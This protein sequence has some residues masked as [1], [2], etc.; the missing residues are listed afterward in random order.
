MASWT[1]PADQTI[2][3]NEQLGR[4]LFAEPLLSGAV[5]Q[6][7]FRGLDLRNFQEK[8]DREYSLDRLGR[9]NVERAVIKYLQP[10]AINAAQ[11]FREPK[12]FD[13]W[14][15][16][17]ARELT[18]AKVGKHVEIFASPVR[19]Q[20][21]EENI[22]H[23]HAL[24]PET[25]DEYSFALHLRNLFASYGGIERAG[26]ARQSSGQRLVNALVRTIRK[27]FARTTMPNR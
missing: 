27:I 14:A 26:A 13:G 4:R 18:A 9:S 1:P 20:G 2:G 6:R 21:M 23:A 24:R 25:T 19:G 22:Y 3:P 12:S 7:Q 10:R 17:R 16:L 8:R 5:D 15:V 11:S